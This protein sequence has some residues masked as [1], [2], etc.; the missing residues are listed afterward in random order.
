[1]ERFTGGDH[2][3]MEAAD[4]ESQA[5]QLRQDLAEEM[6]RPFYKLRPAVYPDGN[7]WCCLY[8]IDL[9][10]GVCGFGD[11]PE[12]AAKDFDY[13]WLHMKLGAAK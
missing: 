7:Q 9:Q 5:A 6:L 1:M 8:G 3:L 11:T 4:C 2:Y 12:L 10:S 13:H